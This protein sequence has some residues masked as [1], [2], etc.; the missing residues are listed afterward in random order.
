MAAQL[1]NHWASRE[2]HSFSV[3]ALWS[4]VVEFTSRETF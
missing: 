4:D 3:V 2:V 1:M